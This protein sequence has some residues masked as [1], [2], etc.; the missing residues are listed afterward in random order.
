MQTS[1]ARIIAIAMQKGGVGKTTTTAHLARAACRRGLTVLVIDLD[2]QGNATSL[3]A[4][5]S[6]GATDIGIA[7]VIIPN[8][9]LDITEVIVPGKWSGLWVAPGVTDPLKNAAYVLEQHGDGAE[10]RVAEALSPARES[11]DLI[12]I[13]TPPALNVITINA[14][15]AADA[16]L[17]VAQGDG[18]SADGLAELRRT[19]R[20]V[21][22]YHNPELAWAGVLVNLWRGTLSEQAW[23]KDM[24]D[25]FTDAAVWPERIPNWTEVKES[26]DH[27]RGLDQGRARFKR[28]AQHYE[29]MIDRLMSDDPWR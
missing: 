18:F 24:E 1:E 4:R 29:T 10:Y 6:I 22:Q 25:S 26:L 9:D 7:D 3:L 15:T 8:A 27:G 13:D 28:L 2:Q 20:K 11:Y 16:L 23:V 21:R 12:L 19:V 17:T 14:L 5:E